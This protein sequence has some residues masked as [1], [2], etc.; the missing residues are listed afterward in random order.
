MFEIAKAGWEEAGFSSEEDEDLEKR[1]PRESADS[2][3]TSDLSIMALATAL[4]AAASQQ[5]IQYLHPSVHILLPNIHPSPSTPE[6]NTFLATLANTGVTVTCGSDSGTSTLAPPRSVS[7]MLAD[8][9]P[10][11]RH[12]RPLSDPL[13]LCTTVLLALAS[14]ISNDA[15]TPLQDRFHPAIR[16]QIEAERVAPMLPTHLWPVLAA[17]TGDGNG[18]ELVCTPAARE[19]F[20]QIIATIATDREL[21]RALLLL[22]SGGGSSGKHVDPAVA[23]VATLTPAQ[24]RGCLQEL[25]AYPLPPAL[26]LPIRTLPAS[27]EFSPRDSTSSRDGSSSGA[28]AKGAGGAKGVS[29]V[30]GAGGAGGAGEGEAF[31]R[32]AHKLSA[33][34]RAI[35]MTGWQRDLTTISSN[36]T[37]AKMIEGIVEATGGGLSGPDVLVIPTARSLVGKAK[38]IEI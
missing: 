20:E 32:I 5:R 37:V 27:E 8:T 2:L 15:A 35:F 24:R 16:K 29:D 33:V 9:S 10:V 13:N 1:T 4:L 36:G 12:G 22:D 30:S 18:R 38:K 25:C 21:E 34:N 26:R 31:R 17:P 11:A 3:A 7:D 19:R 23:A 28:G 6:L 14:D